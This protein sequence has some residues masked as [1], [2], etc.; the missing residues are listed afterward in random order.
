MLRLVAERNKKNQKKYEK[1]KKQ[2]F[3]VVYVAPSE[4][5]KNGGNRYLPSSVPFLR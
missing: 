1:K 4:V 5:V 2:A 3:D